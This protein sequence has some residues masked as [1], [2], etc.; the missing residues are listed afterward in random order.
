MIVVLL[1]IIIILLLPGGVSFLARLWSAVSM[2]IGLAIAYALWGTTGLWVIGGLALALLGV[3][4]FA[5]VSDAARPRKMFL[6]GGPSAT[7]ALQS[8]E[9]PPPVQS[10]TPVHNETTGQE[11]RPLPAAINYDEEEENVEEAVHTGDP[12]DRI[13]VS[14]VVKR[15]LPDLEELLG[16]PGMVEV[17][18]TNSKRMYERPS[19]GPE[20]WRHPAGIYMAVP[21]IGAERIF[22]SIAAA[23]DY[24][25][26][27]ARRG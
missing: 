14:R 25:D 7:S 19:D 1:I 12:F 2:L 21:K 6:S 13:A 23:R 27:H 15:A 18:K 24:H 11:R 9:I 16:Q 5:W 26:R 17:F 10:R 8:V 20:I 22:S 3:F 4:V